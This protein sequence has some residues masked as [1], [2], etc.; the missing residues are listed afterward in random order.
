MNRV[1]VVVVVMCCRSRLDVV[2]DIY[3]DNVC[4]RACVSFLYVCIMPVFFC[5]FV[6]CWVLPNQPTKHSTDK[7]ITTTIIIKMMMMI[8]KTSIN[9]IYLFLTHSIVTHHWIGSDCVWIF[10]NCFFLFW[11]LFLPVD[12]RLIESSVLLCVFFFQ[13]EVQHHQAI[14]DQTKWPNFIWFI[15]SIWCLHD[16]LCFCCC[17]FFIDQLWIWW[18]SNEQQKKKIFCWSKLRQFRCCCYR[19]HSHYSKICRHFSSYQSYRKDIDHHHFQ[20]IIKKIK[21]VSEHHHHLIRMVNN[22]NMIDLFFVKKRN[23]MIEICQIV[24]NL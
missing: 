5:F 4:K 15:F 12:H 19:R 10:F 17:F 22:N 8:Y 3:E 6:F 1:V 9:W 20:I 13:D 16:F 24:K 7:R 23:L 11:K 2:F 14:L 21:V 18:S